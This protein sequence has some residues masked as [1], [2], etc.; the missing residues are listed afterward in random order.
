MNYLTR[1]VPCEANRAESSIHTV[2]SWTFGHF[3]INTSHWTDN[4]IIL[5]YNLL[6]LKTLFQVKTFFNVELD[7]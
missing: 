1:S 4:I 5:A 6:I 2:W 7:M 3:E